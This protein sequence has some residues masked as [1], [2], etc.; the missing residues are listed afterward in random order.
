[1]IRLHQ[2]PVGAQ[3]KRPGRRKVYTKL[4]QL[5]SGGHVYTKRNGPNGENGA[6]YIQV[7]K[8]NPREYRFIPKCGV[9]S[10]RGKFDLEAWYWVIPV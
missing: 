9:R 6:N 7:S 1:M 2:L 10:S 5:G 4:N 8:T 3:F